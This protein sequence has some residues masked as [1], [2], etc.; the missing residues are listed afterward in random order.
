MTAYIKP[1][2][3][4]KSYNAGLPLIDA[5][6]GVSVRE[7]L[8]KLAIP[9]ELVALVMVNNFPKDK[10]Y[11]VHDGDVVQIMAVLGGG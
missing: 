10:D 5:E 1:L 7:T 3:M 8:R 11:I 2:G 6:P 4:L 9:E